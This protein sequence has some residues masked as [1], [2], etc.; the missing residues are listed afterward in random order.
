MYCGKG[1]SGLQQNSCYC[2][3]SCWQPYNSAATKSFQCLCKQ[4]SFSW[5]RT[6]QVW[7]QHEIRHSRHRHMQADLAFCGSSSPVCTT[8][9]RLP[10][11]NTCRMSDD[12][13]LSSLSHYSMVGT[14]HGMVETLHGIDF[15]DER[16]PAAPCMMMAML[17]KA[18][19]LQC[20]SAASRPT[21]V[22]DWIQLPS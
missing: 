11:Q 21:D 18:C 17:D 9:A 2:L 16:D 22:T 4:G 14:S 15:S 8:F 3:Q 13:N 10:A 5:S 19:E 6:R 1:K 20:W 7:T 12:L